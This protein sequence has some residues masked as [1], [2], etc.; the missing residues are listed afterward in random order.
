MIA[1]IG[2]AATLLPKD[3]K[4]IELLGLPTIGALAFNLWFTVNRL[5]S[6]SRMIAY[7]QLFHESV[8]DLRWIGWENALRQYRVWLAH[9]DDEKESAEKSFKDIKQYDNLSFYKPILA[10]HLF[11][12]AA[13]AGLMSFRAWVLGPMT[14]PSGEASVVVFFGINLATVI[15]FFVLALLKYQPKKLKYE[16]ER[17]R[18]LWVAVI[19]SYTNGNLRCIKGTEQQTRP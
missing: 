14:T 5:R 7:V 1:G 6:N 2:L 3:A 17:N 16:I 4:G 13:I 18:I 15:A 12:A 9:C 19:R 11:L 10:L 8:T